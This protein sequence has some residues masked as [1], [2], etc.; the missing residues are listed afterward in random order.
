M[1]I[2]FL[3]SEFWKLLVKKLFGRFLKK[4]S[5]ESNN[6]SLTN[7]SPS[8]LWFPCSSPPS[9]LFSPH[10]RY[11]SQ[12]C[13]AAIL[14]RHWSRFMH[15]ERPPPLKR[16]P[17]YIGGGGYHLLS[18]YNCGFLELCKPKKW[19]QRTFFF[20]FFSPS[21]HSPTSHLEV[22]FVAFVCYNLLA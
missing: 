15:I 4:I 1:K 11:F 13:S 8:R 2:N 9:V 3:F 18:W 22:F 20:F 5:L 17:I 14:R 16:S 10:Y 12:I 21:V 19:R 6:F 7:L